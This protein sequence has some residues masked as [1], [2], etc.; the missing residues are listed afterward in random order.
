MLG[1]IV[2]DLSKISGVQIVTSWDARLGPHPFRNVEV[3]GV[4]KPTEPLPALPEGR[5]FLSLRREYAQSFER[6]SLQSAATL[7]IAPEFDRI[8][9]DLCHRVETIGGKL[10]GPGS[11]AVQQCA[12]KLKLAAVLEEAGVHTISTKPLSWGDASPLEASDHVLHFPVVIKPRDGAGSQNNHLVKSW[13]EFGRLQFFLGANARRQA[14]V[15]QPY[16]TG[17]P[18]SVAIL[19]TE[20]GAHQAFPVAEQWLSEDGRFFYHGGRIPARD[21]DQASIQAAALAAVGCVPGL[22]GYVG[23]DLIVPADEPSRPVVVEINPRLTTSYLG[24]RA[25]ARENLAERMLPGQ[26]N[27]PIEWR[28]GEIEFDSAGNI[29]V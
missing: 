13:D 28:A 17:R 8:L 22:H 20:S 15:W 18:L 29:G 10:L 16:I 24:Y 23:V 12:D 7:L 4:D 9:F 6:S 14:F 1:A 19:I 3:I 2:E 21:V 27:K 5:R 25:L 26:T 11:A